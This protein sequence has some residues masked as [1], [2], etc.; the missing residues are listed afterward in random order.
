[1]IDRD[2]LTLA[3]MARELERACTDLTLAQYRLLALVVGGEERASNL[4]GRLALARPTVSAAIETLVANDLVERTAVDHDRRAI[5]LTIT[6]KGR[7]ALRAA[8]AAMRE[9]LDGLLA[10]VADRSLVEAALGQLAAALATRAERAR[11]RRSAPTS[12]QAAGAAP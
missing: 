9:R 3:W 1:V 8:E 7:A 2:L 10:D 12:A 5:R 6:P 4:A 11:T